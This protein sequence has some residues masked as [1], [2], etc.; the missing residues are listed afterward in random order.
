MSLS[1]LLGL[2]NL[3]DHLVE[4]H[5][6]DGVGVHQLLKL[7]QHGVKHE[8]LAPGVHALPVAG[9]PGLQVI[10]VLGQPAGTA[11]HIYRL[12]GG[13]HNGHPKAAVRPGSGG[14]RLGQR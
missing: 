14:A 4:V 5:A 12:R 13:R 2:R 6:H 10:L 8:L 7:D 9:E 3:G 11:A 1:V